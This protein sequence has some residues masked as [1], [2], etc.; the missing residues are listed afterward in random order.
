MTEGMELFVVA[1]ML[2]LDILYIA[3]L[4]CLWVD[5]SKE[6]R[7]A[8]IKELAKQMMEE[9]KEKEN[10]NETTTIQKNPTYFWYTL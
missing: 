9:E 6:K 2:I 3:T 8:R 5:G 10:K 1:N 7:E 4:I